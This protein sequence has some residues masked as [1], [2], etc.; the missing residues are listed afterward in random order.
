MP[1]FHLFRIHIFIHNIRFHLIHV[2][3]ENLKEYHV[4]FVLN[5]LNLSSSCQNEM[6]KLII[7]S[8]PEQ[9]SFSKI[10][11]CAFNFN[12]FVYL[13]RAIHE[14]SF[15]YSCHIMKNFIMLSFWSAVKFQLVLWSQCWVVLNN[16]E[17]LLFI[18]SFSWFVFRQKL[19]VFKLFCSQFSL[20]KILC[21]RLGGFSL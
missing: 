2:I 8:V 18:V 10:I 5:M 14:K 16:S 6:A 15:K 11:A 13:L 7:F 17:Q 21:S 1:H 3:I 20:V 12:R 19:N 9:V 4:V